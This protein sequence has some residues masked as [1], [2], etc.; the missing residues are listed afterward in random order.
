M[1]KIK[2]AHIEKLILQYSDQDKPSKPEPSKT[3]GEFVWH[4]HPFNEHSGK[5]LSG[6]LDCG[7]ETAR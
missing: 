1:K 6:I 3:L 2:K 7:W 4:N 5:F